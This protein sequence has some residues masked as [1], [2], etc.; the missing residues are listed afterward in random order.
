MNTHPLPPA[1][2][3]KS[4]WLHWRWPK[5]LC[6]KAELIHIH[7]NSICNHWW[8]LQRATYW[9]KNTSVICFWD[10]VTAWTWADEFDEGDD[11]HDIRIR[12]RTR[13]VD[14]PDDLCVYINP[15]G[16]IR[17][18]VYSGD[19]WPTDT[20]RF[21]LTTEMELLGSVMMDDGHKTLRH[22]DICRAYRSCHNE[23]L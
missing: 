16:W 20:D 1:P 12:W 15:S 21:S 9:R 11:S 22:D 14:T 17:Q 23:V 3:A 6:E 7:E 13:S 5:I 4:Y 8:L 19:F 18:L 2:G 10:D